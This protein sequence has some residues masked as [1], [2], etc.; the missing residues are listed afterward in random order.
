MSKKILIIIV[1][2]T[3]LLVLIA[4]KYYS[5]NFDWSKK[6]KSEGGRK[7]LIDHLADLDKAQ[8]VFQIDD[9]ISCLEAGNPIMES[10]PRQCR[11]NDGSLFIED[12]GNTLE[13]SDLIRIDFPLP[14]SEISSPLE[15]SGTARGLWYFEAS[16]PITLVDS[17]GNIIVESFAT[18]QDDWMTEEF[19]PFL[20]QLEFSSPASGSRGKLILKKDNPSGLV[21]HDDFLEIPVIF[22]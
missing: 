20:S 19:V 22:H 8:N 13:K 3:A 11:S 12:I 1:L 14:N 15:I 2:L 4:G 10:Y 16:F 21:E 7:D 5:E 6:E 9:F 18:A 17:K